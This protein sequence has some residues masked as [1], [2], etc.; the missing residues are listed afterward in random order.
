MGAIFISNPPDAPNPVQWQPFAAGAALY[1][2]LLAAGWILTVYNSLIALRNRVNQ[3]WSQVDIQLKRRSDL[4]PNLASCVEG[5]SSH[6]KAVQ[7]LVAELRSQNEITGETWEI[8]GYTTALAAVAENYPALKA[9][10]SFLA[11]Q[12]SLSETE[13]RIALARGYFNDIVTFYNTRLEI[14]PDSFVGAMARLFKQNT[15]KTEDMERAP[16]EVCLAT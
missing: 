15:L 5:Y 11:L 12:K 14:I 10:Q 13:Q 16:V 9:D 4:I 7:L 1:L 8:K 6:E 3:A 2:F